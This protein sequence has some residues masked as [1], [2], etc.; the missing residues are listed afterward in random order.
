MTFVP[1]SIKTKDDKLGHIL[2]TPILGGVISV[3]FALI[4]PFVLT[5]VLTGLLTLNDKLSL[6]LGG[7]LVV[8]WNLFWQY[9]GIKIKILFIPSWIW[10]LVIAVVGVFE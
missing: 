6:V 10:G 7:L 8:G 4:L 1:V 9:Q 2:T 5:G 3:L